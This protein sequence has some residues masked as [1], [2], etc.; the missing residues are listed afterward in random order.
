[1]PIQTLNPAT[2]KIEKTFE[3]FSKEKIEKIIDNAHSAFLSW[4]T[5]SFEE[6]KMF[7]LNATNILRAGKRK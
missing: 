5:T 2:G 3:E 1:M 4:S 7:M 6:R